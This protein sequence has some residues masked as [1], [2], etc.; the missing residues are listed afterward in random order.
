MIVFGSDATYATTN[1]VEGCDGCEISVLPA[2]QW[3]RSVT[4]DAT[5]AL[6]ADV[7]VG[8]IVH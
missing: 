5:C 8:F 1:F 6:L 4:I 3:K 7:Q 2:V